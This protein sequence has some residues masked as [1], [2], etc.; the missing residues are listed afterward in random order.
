MAGPATFAHMLCDWQLWLWRECCTAVFSTF[1]LDRFHEKFVTKF[2]R[3]LIPAE[4]AGFARRWLGLYP[5]LP[6]RLA[7]E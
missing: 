6:P 3:G 7:N 2:G 4:K 1:K 5:D